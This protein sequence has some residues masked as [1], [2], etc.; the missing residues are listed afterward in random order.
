QQL[1]SHGIDSCLLAFTQYHQQAVDLF[2]PFNHE[3]C[4]YYLNSGAAVEFKA[5]ITRKGVITIRIEAASGEN[6]RYDWKNKISIQLTQLGLIEFLCAFL[7]I[8]ESI[9]LKHYG[10]KND[11]SLKVQYQE[12]KLF[13]QVSQKGKKLCGVPIPMNEAV[14]IGLFALD[15]YLKNF[16]NI[17]AEFAV[18]NF[19]RAASLGL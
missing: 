4:T 8:K 9:E 15:S 12:G 1:V 2:S 3:W 19:N 18:Q 5:D 17:S 14:R 10:A 6:K 13:L 11:K 16:D 7:F